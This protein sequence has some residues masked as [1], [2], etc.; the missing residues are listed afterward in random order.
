MTPGWPAQLLAERVRH[1]A[2]P[3]VPAHGL[4]LESV[5]YP[6]DDQL[7]ARVSQARARRD[8]ML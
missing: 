6:P 7:A 8:M 1:P 2:S 4:C 3:V 5:T